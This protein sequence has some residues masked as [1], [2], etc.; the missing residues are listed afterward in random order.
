M[1]QLQQFTGVGT[2]RRSDGSALSGERRY[3]ITLVPW[4]EPERPL[5]I[6]SWV[7]LHD[8][9][10]L[11]LENEELTVQLNDGRWFT[12]RVIHVSETAPHHHVFIAQAWPTQWAGSRGAGT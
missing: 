12:F 4:Y 10:A 11:E 8:Q 2:V 6:G 5:A 7:E 3:S 1:D 9:E